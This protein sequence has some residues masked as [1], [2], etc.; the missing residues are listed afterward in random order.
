MVSHG[1]FFRAADAQVPAD[2]LNRKTTLEQHF[3][4][5]DLPGKAQAQRSTGLKPTPTHAKKEHLLPEVHFTSAQIL[6]ESRWAGQS[7]PSR[8]VY[9]FQQ[10]QAGI[11]QTRQPLRRQ[12]EARRRGG[13]S[14]L[15]QPLRL[16]TA[17]SLIK[18]WWRLA[19][20]SLGVPCLLGTGVRCESLGSLLRGSAPLALIVYD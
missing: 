11:P 18:R 19:R 9:A 4:R 15:P 7:K 6:P 5:S 8:G 16:N 3:Q 13:R 20:P 17:E 14:G 12:G 2:L 10:S 1:S